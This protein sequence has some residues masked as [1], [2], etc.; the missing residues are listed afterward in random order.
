MQGRMARSKVPLSRFNIDGFHPIDIS[1]QFGFF[2]EEDVRQF[3]N[4]FFGINSLEAAHMDPQQ[5]KLLELV[6]ECFENANYTLQ[7]LAGKNVGCFV[8]NFTNDFQMMQSKDPEFFSRYTATGFGPSLMANRISHIFDLHGPSMTVDTA[9]SSS[10]Y[11]LHLACSALQRQECEAAICA[12]ANLILSPEVLIGASKSGIISPTSACHT[13]DA[14]ADGYAR[15]EGVGALFLKTLSSAKRDGDR[16]R[17]IIRGTAVNR[18]LSDT[19][20][21]RRW[22]NSLTIRY[23]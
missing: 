2:L 9:C 23:L 22:I 20:F 14:S 3:D 18:Y 21:N 5:R 15:G 8:G 13:F 12:S 10:L 16:I 1:S 19:L 11:S 4:T 17:A 7:N 6:F